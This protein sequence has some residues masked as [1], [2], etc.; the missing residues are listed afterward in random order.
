MKFSRRGF[1]KGLGVLA[2]GLAAPTLTTPKLKK[3]PQRPK[4]RPIPKIVPRG[5]VPDCIL[6][7]QEVLV[8]TFEIVSCP[9]VKRSDVKARRFYI[10]DRA[11]IQAKES[12]QREEDQNIFKAINKAIAQKPTDLPIAA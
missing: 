11:L 6:E 1:L 8:P 7:G 9:T 4:Q 2:V 12:I 5:R 10:V 3:R